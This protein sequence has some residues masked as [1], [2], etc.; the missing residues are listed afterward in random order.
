MRDLN[1]AY[2]TIDGVI[3]TIVW[4]GYREGI[5]DVR[6]VTTLTKAIELGKASTDD[7]LKTIAA[8]AQRYLATLE[9]EQRNL[10]TIRLVAIRYLLKLQ[11]D[12][13]VNP[14][15]LENE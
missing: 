4:E 9:V 5:D 2:P 3:D 12:Q 15:V 11:G 13:T 1:L 7:K 14:E 8:E 10:D 6:Y